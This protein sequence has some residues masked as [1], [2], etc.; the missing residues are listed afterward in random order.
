VNVSRTVR[1]LLTRGEGFEPQPPGEFADSQR[2]QGY[3]VD[4]RA[5][6]VSPKPV[7][8]LFP[9]GVAQLALG[10]WERSLAGEP[11]DRF[12]E[13]SGLLARRA[14]Q[15]DGA[16]VWPYAVRVPKFGL[17]PGWLSAL[18]QGQ[19]A[20]VFVRAHQTTGED[21]WAEFALLAVEPLLGSSELVTET[22]NGPVLEEAPCDPPNHILNG[23]IYGLWGLWDAAVG[24]D[25]GRSRAGFE[26]GIECLRRSLGRYDLGWWTR[27]SLLAGRV[28]DIAHPFYH[29]LHIDQT[30]TLHR[31]TGFPEFREASERWRTYDRPPARARALAHKVLG[32]ALR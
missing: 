16:L 5:K 18:A 7:E 4:F 11:V 15:R 17:E 30:A 14:G 13:L 22:E 26:A 31:L 25:D 32:R 20:S 10:W 29:R 24:L 19:I 27:Y 2:V 21:R 23:W 8:Q 9:G 28:S 12:L 1:V 6:T 3:F